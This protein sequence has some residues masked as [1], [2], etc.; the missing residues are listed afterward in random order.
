[1]F[2]RKNREINIVSLSYLDVLSGALA[3]FIIIV[4]ILIPYYRKDLVDMSEE[5]RELRQ[6]LEAVQERLR[7]SEARGEALQGE[8]ARLQEENR[9]QGEEVARL[10][11]ENQSL[12]DQLGKTYFIVLV[13]WSNPGD[14]IDLHVV[15]PDGREY[16]FQKKTHP[17][18]NDRLSEDDTKGPGIEVFESYEAKPGV[19]SIYYRFYSDA[20]P[21]GPVAVKGRIFYK[22][23]NMQ[24]GEKTLARQGEKTLIAKVRVKED[25]SLER[26]Q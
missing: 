9:Q 22:Q 21:T 8:N 25:G 1:M 4:M 14:D 6:R 16:Y 15:T 10:E 12:I 13:S 19:Y 5:L 3:V 20:S 7:A 26:L 23:G 24:L 2:K 18:S 11:R 17:G